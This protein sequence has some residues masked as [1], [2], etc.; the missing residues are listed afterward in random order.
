MDFSL[1]VG[2]EVL[3]Q[4]PDVLRAMLSKLSDGWITGD[5]GPDTWS[6]YQVVGHLAFIEEHDW[7]DRT[8]VILKHGIDRVFDP[9]D[10][11]AGFT[12]FRDWS[13]SDLLDRFASARATNLTTLQELVENA[14]L[15]RRGVHPSFGEVT[16]SQLLAT[17]VVHDLNHLGQIVKTMAKQYSQAVGPWRELLPIIDAP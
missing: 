11:E 2:A 14:D 3:R 12:Q 9:V 13:L 15:S 8:Q 6:P 16:I 5:E 1:D 4:T 10:R 7:I 17:W